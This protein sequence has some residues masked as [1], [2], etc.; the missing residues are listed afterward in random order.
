MHNAIN[1]LLNSPKDN[2]FCIPDNSP[3]TQLAQIVAKYGNDHSEELNG[4]AVLLE[5]THLDEHFLVGS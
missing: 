3:V 2:T 1:A 5:T 4:A